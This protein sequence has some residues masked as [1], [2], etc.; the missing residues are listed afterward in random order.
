MSTKMTEQKALALLEENLKKYS[1]L[2]LKEAGTKDL[3]K[4]LAMISHDIL[5]D[6]REKFHSKV[7]KNSG[8]S[9]STSV[10]H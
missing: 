2:S 5:F 3:Y 6:L 7:A 8:K 4:V 9:A 10:S 1:E